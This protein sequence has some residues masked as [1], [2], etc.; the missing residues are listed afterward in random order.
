MR[1]WDTHSVGKERHK[2][3]GRV[4]LM[5]LSWINAYWE[6]SIMAHVI[7]VLS[8]T[9]WVIRYR[10][11]RTWH[12]VCTRCRELCF[13]FLRWCIIIVATCGA[14]GINRGKVCVSHLDL[15]HGVIEV[16]GSRAVP[17]PVT[18]SLTTTL[19]TICET[20]RCHRLTLL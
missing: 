16:V 5:S 4:L 15:L 10:M 6:L 8:R 18:T 9:K 11:G 3:V 14:I 7:I 13:T 2:L 20:R 19:A 1:G 12:E 17:T